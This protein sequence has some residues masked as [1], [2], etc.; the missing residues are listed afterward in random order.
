MKLSA[1]SHSNYFLME[2]QRIQNHVLVSQPVSF[3]WAAAE[4]VHV[5]Q[6]LPDGEVVEVML[7]H[8]PI[9]DNNTM[10]HVKSQGQYVSAPEFPFPLQESLQWGISGQQ[11]GLCVDSWG[12]EGGIGPVTSSSSKPHSQTPCGGPGLTQP[13]LPFPSHPPTVLPAALPLPQYAAYLLLTFLKPPK[14]YSA[15][16]LVVQI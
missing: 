1:S 5:P 16:K 7:W 8:P 12:M 3:T 10:C 14:P 15:L 6:L 11:V 9:H 13:C 2:K 4:R